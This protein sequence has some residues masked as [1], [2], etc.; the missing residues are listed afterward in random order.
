M[1]AGFRDRPMK[2]LVK[3]ILTVGI[4]SAL[5]YVLLPSVDE[6]R[7]PAPIVLEIVPPG[8]GEPPMQAPEIRAPATPTG[9]PPVE[10]AVSENPDVDGVAAPGPVLIDTPRDAPEAEPVAPETALSEETGTAPDHDG[11]PEA[12]SSV[13][14]ALPEDT[15][16]L[17]GP[18]ETEDWVEHEIQSGDTLARVFDQHDLSATELARLL[19]TSAETKRLADLRPGQKILIRKG[20][21]GKLEELL[22]E[23][24]SI[25]R[26]RITSSDDGY[27]AT[28]EEKPVETQ[29]ES[30][31]ATIDSSLFVDGQAAG[32][33]D[34]V[35]MEL[36]ELFNW[37][38]DFA[39][40]LQTG[41]R[42]AVIYEARYVDGEKYD[43]G[44]I[45]AAEFINNGKAYRALRYRDPKGVIDYYAPDGS[46]KKKAFIKTP[47]KFGRISSR[48]S[49]KRWH[50]VLKRWRSH[51]GV[52]YAAPTGTPVKASGKGTV[53]FI[54]RQ[55]GYGKVI[56]LKHGDRYTTVYGHLSKYARGLSK[57]D[58]VR[59]G[60]IIGYVGQ[61]G[62]ATGP[63]L[64]YEFRVN[65]KHVDPLSHELPTAMPLPKQYLADF[66][67]KADP[68]VEQLNLLSAP[69]IAD[70]E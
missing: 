20:A 54:G 51:K 32:L 46:S 11:T 36:A 58:S 24:S 42:F 17:T 53:S 27:S 2:V 28:L 25:A 9:T 23:R 26:L 8:S 65:G 67:Q 70:Q 6:P 55:R 49:K 15:E 35:I 16:S 62:L 10:I 14:V 4:L 21:D 50:P 34:K 30:A 31:A 12:T 69:R 48:F 52:D 56:Y 38:I 66:H 37:D 39:R 43:D 19:D 47:V 18:H 44:D 13:D 29:V 5:V 45:L 61:T 1:L 68:L 59:Q 41:D 64:H 33:S 3:A 63:H 60:E 40:E 22:H 7:Q 57:G